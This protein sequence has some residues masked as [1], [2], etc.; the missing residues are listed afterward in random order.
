LIVESWQVSLVL[1]IL[2]AVA[3]LLSLSFGLLGMAVGMLAVA[4]AQFGLG[5]LSLSRD[6]LIF[7]VASALAFLAFRL[8]FKR[9][10]DQQKLQQ[11]D[12]N[13]Y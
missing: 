4:A 12:I 6:V 11:D 13:Q 8:L 9:R 3:E 7:A 10:S 2:F 5:G 1:A